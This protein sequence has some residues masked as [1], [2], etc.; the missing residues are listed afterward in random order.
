MLSSG[1]HPGCQLAGH[2]TAHWYTMPHR[3]PGRPPRRER[4]NRA[5]RL[6]RPWFAPTAV[7]EFPAEMMFWQGAGPALP[8]DPRG[9]P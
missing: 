4:A 9:N 3:R 1:G 7:I 8:T 2:W 6:C 5:A